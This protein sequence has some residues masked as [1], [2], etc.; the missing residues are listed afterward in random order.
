MPRFFALEGLA[1]GSEEVNAK[2]LGVGGKAEVTEGLDAKHFGISDF[3]EVSL[4]LGAR[5]PGVADEEKRSGALGNGRPPYWL[6][7]TG[8]NGYNISDCAR[9]SLGLR[10]GLSGVCAI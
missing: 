4:C 10:A 2:N 9:L 6:K 3:T 7:C 8:A 1:L 5:D